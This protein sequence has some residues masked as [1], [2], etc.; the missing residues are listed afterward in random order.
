MDFYKSCVQLRI[1]RGESDFIFEDVDVGGSGVEI[2]GG[3]G[4]NVSFR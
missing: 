3:V 1:Q 4:P 2:C